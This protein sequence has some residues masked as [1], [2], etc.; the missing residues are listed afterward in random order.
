MLQMCS[1]CV[2]LEPYSGLQS[3]RDT[4]TDYYRHSQSHLE[5]Y[6]RVPKTLD[7]V[8]FVAAQTEFK[9][10]TINNNDLSHVPQ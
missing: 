9:L 7:S 5:L 3:I 10:L 6:R 8:P 1:I 4:D 2:L